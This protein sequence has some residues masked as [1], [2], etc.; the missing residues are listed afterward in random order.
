MLNYFVRSLSIGLVAWAA[1]PP[2]AACTVADLPA[3]TELPTNSCGDLLPMG[4][5]IPGDSPALIFG[6]PTNYSQW[7]SGSET[8]RA[9]RDAINMKVNGEPAEFSVEPAARGRYRLV[10]EQGLEE[11]AVYEVTS[12]LC[13]PKQPASD[14]WG[15]IVGPPEA[16]EPSTG[17]LSVA[18]REYFG[19]DDKGDPDDW[20]CGPPL[21]P[22]VKVFFDLE[23][24]AY[25]ERYAAGA[26]L[27]LYVDGEEHS[28]KSYEQVAF[29]SRTSFALS[30]DTLGDIPAVGCGTHE[31]AVAGNILGVGMV[32]MSEP[33]IVDFDCDAGP[34]AAHGCAISTARFDAR[35][36]GS[37]ALLIGLAALARRCLRSK[38]VAP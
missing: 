23:P 5:S 12:T 33:L 21:P 9:V 13:S 25:L 6:L 36:G 19:T 35:L 37:A 20:I 4:E 24:S 28:Y 16:A 17:R 2:V 3:T 7:S 32:P 22:G 31:I 18:R 26:W 34:G 30:S 1:A 8:T 29:A 27:Q 38:N 14:S 10:P 15:F 11:G